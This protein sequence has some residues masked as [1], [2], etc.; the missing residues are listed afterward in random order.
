MLALGAFLCGAEANEE[1]EKPIFSKAKIG[2]D[3]TLNCKSDLETVTWKVIFEDS[4]ETQAVEPSEKYE[5]T[6][7]LLK[8]DDVQES[9][10]GVYSCYNDEGTKMKSFKL[11]VS[12]KLR[13][14]PLSIS[15]DEGSK[16]VIRCHIDASD[17]DIR[18]DWYSRPEGEED[19]TV[20][21][22]VCAKTEE[23]DC[24]VPEAQA[25]FEATDKSI[26]A[27]PLASRTSIKTETDDDG[28]LTSTLTIVDT[29]VSDRRVFIC[30][31]SL[32]EAESSALANCKESKHCDRTDTVLR[33][34][35]PLAAVWPFCGIVVEVILLCVIIFFCEKRKTG[36]EKEDYDEGSKEN[37]VSG[38]RQHK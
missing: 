29:E 10:L 1:H 27:V 5:M 26:P 15:I 37:N 17:Q 30:Q 33:V 12:V 14:L 21:N 25:L 36:E 8:I 16:A 32:K 28:L 9:E 23:S 20:L 18:I 2:E 31:A 13:H 38:G 11:D 35:D 19:T 4:N 6:G 3:K 24:T 7:E 22:T 34:K